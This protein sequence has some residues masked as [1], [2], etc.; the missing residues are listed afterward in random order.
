MDTSRGDHDLFMLPEKLR[1]RRRVQM[2]RAQVALQR[3]ARRSA[4][5]ELQARRDVHG[6]GVHSGAAGSQ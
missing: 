2:L 5:R 3:E 4:Q 1:N 6:S